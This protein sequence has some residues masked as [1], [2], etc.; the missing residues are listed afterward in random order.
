M[1]RKPLK[2]HVAT[3]GSVKHGIQQPDDYTNISAQTGIKIATAN[4]VVDDS[5]EVQSLR[6][7]GKLIKLRCRLANK[8]TNT[9]LC[10]T[11]KVSGAI[12][13]LVGKSLDGSTIT[14]VTI[15]QKRNRR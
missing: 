10:T 5:T 15:P 6:A 1:A 14:S 13:G 4:Q 11:E 12:A 3:I 7:S 9:V 2:L 8:K